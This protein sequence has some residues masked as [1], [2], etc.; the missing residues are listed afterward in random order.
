MGPHA[1][2]WHD[3]D[4]VVMASEFHTHP[5]PQGAR[6]H[7]PPTNPTHINLTTKTQ[8]VE[9][10]SCVA[11]RAPTQLVSVACTKQTLALCRKTPTRAGICNLK[12]PRRGETRPL[13][14]N[15]AQLVKSYLSL[16]LRGGVCVCMWLSRKSDSASASIEFALWLADK[17]S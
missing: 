7:I 11:P 16:T 12:P 9:S 10:H 1:G 2:S 13:P 5:A 6:N 3:C 15:R 8:V 14:A 17:L 4:A